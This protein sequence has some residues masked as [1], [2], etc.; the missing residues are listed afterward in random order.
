MPARSRLLCAMIIV[1]ALCPHASARQEP[2]AVDKTGSGPPL[3]FV[4]GLGCPGA[5][6]DPVVR[7]LSK[8]H[9]C[10]TVSIDGFAGRPVVAGTDVAAVETAIAR[11]AAA[12]AAP[13]PVLIAHSVGGSLALAVAA[14]HPGLFGRIIIVDAYPFPPAVLQPGI[15]GKQAVAQA[16]ALESMMLRQSD[17]EFGAQQA[18]VARMMVT[19]PADAATLLG[20]LKAS[21]R[22][23]LAETQA[24]A[25]SRDLRS[26]L[27]RI[28]V[29]LLVIGTWKGREALGL[30]AESVERQIHDQYGAVPHAAVISDTSR[31][32]VMLDEP[33]WLVAQIRRFLGE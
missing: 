21:D 26:D 17:E 33:A 12:H 27:S 18:A 25:L 16:A 20:W 24:R 8:T 14:A 4:P 3:M 22:T 13:R 28:H 23:M 2:L 9:M 31:H 32:F 19:S 7:E 5:V 10:L 30:T 15:S 29:P 6:W 1:A 11:V